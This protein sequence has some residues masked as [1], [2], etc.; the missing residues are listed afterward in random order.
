MKYDF[1]LFDLDGTLTDPA[2][3]I[4]NSVMYALEKFG[5]APPERKQLYKFIGPPL[6]YSFEKFYGFSE[7]DAKLALK[8]Y[9]EYFADRGIF[10]NEKYCG[11]DLLLS[12]LSD[13]GV[14]IVLATSKPDVYAEKILRRFELM[15]YFYFV[16]GN[17]LDESRSEKCDVIRYAINGCGIADISRAV[18]IGDR[19]YDIFGAKAVGMDSIGVTYGYGSRKE[20]ENA[21]ATYISDS[22]DAI[23]TLIE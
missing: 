23:F 10:E 3:G 2:L 18:M 19:E 8:Y 4:T 12:R 22:V 17:T 16:S 11:I 21:G 7:S 13:S 15:K 9:R 20:L 1:A 14:K 6:I 5:I